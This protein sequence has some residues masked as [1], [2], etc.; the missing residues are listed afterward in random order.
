VVPDNALVGSNYIF[1]VMPWD[2][3]THHPHKRSVF[4]MEYLFMGGV[5]NC[6]YSQNVINV[7]IIYKCSLFMITR[8]INN[9]H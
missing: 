1:L 6:F 7:F 5:I 3:D 8:Y 4:G 2:F 9:V